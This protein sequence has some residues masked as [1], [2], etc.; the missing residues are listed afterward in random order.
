MSC[1]EVAGQVQGGGGLTYPGIPQSGTCSTAAFLQLW[2]AHHQLGQLSDIHVELDDL[3]APRFTTQASFNRQKV[4]NRDKKTGN[5]QENKKIG[6][7]CLMLK[8]HC[9]H[10]EDSK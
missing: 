8:C 3:V 6:M 10:Q 4:V 9:R 2:H 7:V 1:E 5:N